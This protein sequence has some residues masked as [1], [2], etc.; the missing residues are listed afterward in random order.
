MITNRQAANWLTKRRRERKANAAI[1]KYMNT[2]RD[3]RKARVQME[4]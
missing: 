4:R 3:C 2:E 1:L